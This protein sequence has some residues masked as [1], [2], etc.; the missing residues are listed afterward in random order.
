[1]LIADIWTVGI[2]YLLGINFNITTSAVPIAVVGIGTAYSIHIISK[3]YEELHRGISASEA[4]NATLKHVGT[5]VVLSA[6]TTIAGF[7][8][9]LTADLTQSGNWVYLHLLE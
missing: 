4:V 7:L 6:L 1:M 3:Y 5:A 2:M 8:S 9:L